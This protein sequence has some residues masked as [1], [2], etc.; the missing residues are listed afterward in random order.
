MMS[1][2][3]N[4]DKS[5]ANINGLGQAVER[6]WRTMPVMCYIQTSSGEERNMAAAPKNPGLY[7]GTQPKTPPSARINANA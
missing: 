5:E 6:T 3:E 7:Q 1:V 4:V 2:M